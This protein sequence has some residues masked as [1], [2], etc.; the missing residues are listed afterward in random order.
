MVWCHYLWRPPLHRNILRYNNRKP[1]TNNPKSHKTNILCRYRLDGQF[2]QCLREKLYPPLLDKRHFAGE[3]RWGVYTLKTP[4]LLCG[5]LV[6][7]PL[8]Y[9][10]PK[11]R[12]V[13]S[14][15]GRWGCIGSGPI[16]N[17]I[18]SGI[19]GKVSLPR[20]GANGLSRVLAGSFLHSKT[21]NALRDSRNLGFPKGGFCEGGRISIIGVVRAP[22][23]I[24]NFAPNPCENV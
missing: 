17:L 14:G 4:P 7:P 22:V 23:A 10:P 21:E 1:K 11:P 13:L 6:C 16:A 12:R 20:R 18:S 8:S 9:T 24:I 19:K 2:G 15:V 5:N 3:G